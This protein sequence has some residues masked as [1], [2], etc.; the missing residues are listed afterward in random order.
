MIDNLKDYHLDLPVVYDP[1][2]IL[3]DD[4]RTDNIS[5]EQFTKSTLAFCKTIQA[6][7]YEPMIYSNM[8]WEAF[9]LDLSQLTDYP[10]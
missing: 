10:I 2:S 1:E 6:A 9:E 8:L 7:G 5:G 4:A 3:D